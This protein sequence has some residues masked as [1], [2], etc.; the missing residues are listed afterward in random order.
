MRIKVVAGAL[1]AIAALLWAALSAQQTQPLPGFGTGIVPITGSVTIDN[2]PTVSALQEGMWSVSVINA[3]EV[4]VAN[5]P[6]VSVAAA[7]FL[8]KG[9]RYAVTWSAGEQET[10]TIADPG[11][12]G[13]VRIEAPDRRQRW[14]NLAVAR[15]IEDVP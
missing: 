6:V 15:S 5:R 11:A 13:W 7:E 3:P 12:G 9:T 4:R 14:I 8:K 1:F 10:V 2:V